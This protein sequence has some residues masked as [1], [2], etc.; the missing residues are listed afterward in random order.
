MILIG[1]VL[2]LKTIVRGMV[3]RREH[4]NMAC[5]RDAHNFQPSRTVY[6]SLLQTPRVYHTV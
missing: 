3:T 1:F 6:L 2:L 5:V 4:D